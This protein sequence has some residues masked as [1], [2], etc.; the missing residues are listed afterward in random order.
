MKGLFQFKNKL[1]SNLKQRSQIHIPPVRTVSS[2][3]DS[4]KFL[5]LKIWKLIPDEMKE[6]ES[7]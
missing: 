4:I 1:P 7:L 6:L 2:G 5:G 3:T